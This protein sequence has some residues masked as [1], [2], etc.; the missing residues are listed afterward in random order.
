[1]QQ[2]TVNI[3]CMKWGDKYGANYVNRLYSMVSRN[4]TLPFRF[5][6]FTDDNSGLSSQVD[7]FPIIDVG[8]DLNDDTGR[9]RVQAWK[10]LTTLADP[11]YDIDGT[12][13]FLDLDIVITDN[14]DCFFE[15]EGEFFIIKEWKSTEN[16]G[17]SSV[18]RFEAGHLGAI[19]DYF[20]EHR[21]SIV[22]NYANEQLYLTRKVEASGKLNFWP[23][24]WCPSYRIHCLPKNRLKRWFVPGK[25]P[26]ASKII[27]F[28]GAPDP[29]D[30]INGKG[31]RWYRQIKATPWIADYWQ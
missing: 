15:A 10:K 25:K 30:A 29:E 5:I 8:A 7:S 26:E 13:L 27:V 1:M 3:L 28:H 23:E 2:K 20:V 19:L 22:S 6:C 12:C 24:D 31:D 14:I 16:N 4:L 21:D 11:L 9:K 17:N 18:Y